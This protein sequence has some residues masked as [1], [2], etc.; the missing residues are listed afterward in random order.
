MKVSVCIAA[1]NGEKYIIDQIT[2]I[3]QQLSIDDEIIIVDDASTDKTVQLLNTINDARIKVFENN[4]NKGH[5]QSFA[6]AISLATSE[7][8][9]T[10]DQDDI[11]VDGR[12]SLMK[13]TIITKKTLLV[14]SNSSFIDSKNNK[15][16]FEIDGVSE[17]DSHKHL[18]N[19]INIFLGKTNYY[20]CTMAFHT[21]L[22]KIILPIPTY[23]E[24]HDLWI[25]IAANI[26]KSNE[27]LN[28]VTLFRRIHG[29]NSSILNRSFLKKIKSRFVF[30]IS[31]IELLR[32]NY[33]HR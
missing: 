7:I 11:W 16:D 17:K 25:A 27:H 19:I 29:T 14:T 24:S 4:V 15:I 28:N 8:I 9:F 26:A 18:E 2:S 5:V 12:L 3:L 32:R 6:Y 30:A 31:I 10:A 20:G 33:L 23:V 13:Q 1:Y 21:K 22:K